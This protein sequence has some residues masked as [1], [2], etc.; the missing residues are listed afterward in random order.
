MKRTLP[1]IIIIAVL[2]VALGAGWYLTRPTPPTTTIVSPSS[3]SS[4]SS[5]S[6]NAQTRPAAL[7]GVPGAEPAHTLGSP[8]ARVQLEEFGDF[9][10]PPCAMFHPVLKQMHQ[11][12]GDRL[13]ITF[14]NYPLVPPHNNAVPAASAAEA[15][16]MQGKAKFW[17]MHALIYEHQNDWKNLPDT[18]PLFEGYAKQIGLDVERFKRD[19]ASEQVAQRIFLDG[20]R[21]RS[22]GVRGTPTV[23][24][25]G[26]ELAFETV[27]AA[28]KLRAAIQNELNA[29]AAQ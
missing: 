21:G 22:L 15:A 4:P 8:N 2:L 12:F 18:R 6:S 28:D 20:K 19:F 23:F 16:G 14:R 9:Q 3:P 29:V 17:E 13:F 7:T 10:C 27:I 26:R 24:L 1:F 11:E 25:N 5:A